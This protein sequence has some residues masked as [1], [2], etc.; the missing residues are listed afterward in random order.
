MTFHCR[1]GK[2]VTTTALL[3]ISMK[4]EILYV[5]M[6][7]VGPGEVSESNPSPSHCHHQTPNSL[8]AHNRYSE[9]EWKAGFFITLFE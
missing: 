1:S 2:T 3:P 8:H 9:A 6:R 5:E 7:L 4:L